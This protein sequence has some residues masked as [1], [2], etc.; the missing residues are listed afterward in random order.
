MPVDEGRDFDPSYIDELVEQQERAYGGHSNSDS[1]SS[2]IIHYM[3]SSGPK[4][5]WLHLIYPFQAGGKFLL[6][7][8]TSSGKGLLE[9]AAHVFYKVPEAGVQ[10]IHYFAKNLH[11]RPKH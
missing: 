5:F 10:A 4:K 9:N 11:L 8:I 7:G 3:Y 1:I 2:D 6:N